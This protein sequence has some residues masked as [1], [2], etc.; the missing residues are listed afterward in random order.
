MTA[1]T[2]TC[3]TITCDVCGDAWEG[4]GG[5]WHWENLTEA[6][7][8]ASN[9]NWYIGADG[10]A[11][12]PDWKDDHVAKAR[13]ILPNLNDHDRVELETVRPWLDDEDEDDTDPAPGDG[14]QGACA[15]CGGLIAWTARDTM[16]RHIDWD[17]TRPEH[18][19]R[20][21]RLA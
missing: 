4:D 18:A 2:R 15:R 1:T 12:C 13:E 14:Q 10:V 17:G 3:V 16:W 8:T 21:G 9:D 19:A 6:R 5:A 11:I 7:E 20:A